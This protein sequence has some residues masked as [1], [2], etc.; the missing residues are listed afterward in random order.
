MLRPALF[1]LACAF[2]LFV[3]VYRISPLYVQ[4]PP[5]DFGPPRQPPLH[6]PR[7]TL[8]DVLN[9]LMKK[10]EQVLFDLEQGQFGCDGFDQLIDFD[11]KNYLDALQDLLGSRGYGYEMRGPV[12]VIYDKKLRALGEQYPLNRTIS[13]LKL[14]DVSLK[15][16]F[17][18]IGRHLHARID[19]GAG[20]MIGSNPSVP[21]HNF[22]VELSNIT[23]REALFKIAAQYGCQTWITQT[24]TIGTK[25]FVSIHVQ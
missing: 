14:T 8:S 2:I 9:A 11:K 4:G 17:D 20:P 13:S 5:I 18:A 10:K 21:L 15:E 6:P 3:F 19:G 7:Y 1:W 23:L 25:T 22:N 12:M 16:C 24:Y